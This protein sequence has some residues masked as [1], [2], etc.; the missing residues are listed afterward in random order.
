MKQDGCGIVL[1]I[2]VLESADL[3][4]ISEIAKPL[5]DQP[6][7]LL[8]SLQDGWQLVI[9]FLGRLRLWLLLGVVDR[10]RKSGL[11]RRWLVVGL[12]AYSLG[13]RNVCHALPLGGNPTFGHLADVTLVALRDNGHVDL[14]ATRA[15][16]SLP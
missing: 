9:G 10:S 12:L 16:D 6:R 7:F 15:A 1:L 8:C 14:A 11:R 13:L 2:D 3:Q 4:W 5:I